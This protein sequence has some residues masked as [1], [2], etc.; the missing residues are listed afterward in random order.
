[1]TL[2]CRWTLLLALAL[3]GT[4]A[5]AG[6]QPPTP[7]DIQAQPRQ[8]LIMLHLPPPR[9]QPGSSYRAYG[10]DNGRAARQAI[11]QDLARKY[12]LT[13]QARWPMPALDIDC[14]VMELAAGDAAEPLLERLA[15]DPRVK[16]AQAM[17]VF[18]GMG[19]GDPLAAIQPGAGKRQIEHI[20]KTSTG[21]AMRVA[22]IDSGVDDGHPDLLGQVAIMQNFIDGKPY[23]PEA[24][25]T[26][27]AG[28]I[29]ARADNGIGIA[30]VAPGA[31]LLALR[32]CWEEPSRVTLCNSFTLGKA[33]NF[34][35]SND[36]HIINL[37]LSGPPDRLLQ[38]LLEVALA[39]G[40]KVVGAIDPRQADGGFPASHPGVLAVA[41][42]A[43]QR[44]TGRF[45]VAPGRDIPTTSV[46]ARWRLASGSSYSAAYVSGLLALIG[47][48]RP[49]STLEPGQAFIFADTTATDPLIAGSVDLCATLGKAAGKCVCPCPAQ[50]AQKVPLY[51]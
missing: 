51:P 39:R 26:G 11:A 31:R 40:I 25:G 49:L 46:G 13:L 30:G 48:L 44:F 50:H 36:A 6:A 27:I 41:D 29:A 12:K 21:R 8:I 9:F 4:G 38:R 34:A 28:I 5:K 32:A 16:W 10:D 1:M 35:I 17:A 2:L 19:Q 43:K 20:H 3:A 22:I 24:H 18:T 33:L 45:V 47:E 23:L 37:S 7:Q 15:Q 14:F 42:G